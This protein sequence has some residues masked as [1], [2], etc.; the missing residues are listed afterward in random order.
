MGT[1]VSP[2]VANLYM[3]NFENKALNF[4]PP[5]LDFGWGV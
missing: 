1:P 4:T 5:L 3:N 2:I